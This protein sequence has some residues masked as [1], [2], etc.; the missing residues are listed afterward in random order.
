MILPT[1]NPNVQVVRTSTQNTKKQNGLSSI[2]EDLIEK[3]QL[4]VLDSDGQKV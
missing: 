1:S 2:L 3:G 4:V